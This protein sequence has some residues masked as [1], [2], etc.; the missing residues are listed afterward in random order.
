[1]QVNSKQQ[2]SQKFLSILR[3]MQKGHDAAGKDLE[4]ALSSGIHLFFCLKL[5]KKQ[6]K[7]STGDAA[8]C[9]RAEQSP[10]KRV[11]IQSG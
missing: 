11:S 9:N 3:A 1:M 2:Y 6:T 4:M 7:S 5:P 8:D 10:Q